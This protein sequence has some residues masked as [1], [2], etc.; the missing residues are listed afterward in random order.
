MLGDKL[1]RIAAFEEEGKQLRTRHE[2]TAK[3]NAE[4]HVRL[5]SAHGEDTVTATL[6]DLTDFLRGMDAPDNQAELRQIMRD[7][8]VRKPPCHPPGCTSGCLRLTLVS[9]GWREVLG[10]AMSQPMA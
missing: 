6:E 4:A 9:G 3:S 5:L 8:D 10:G 7:R 2:V 1:H